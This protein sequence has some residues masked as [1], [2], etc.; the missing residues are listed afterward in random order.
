MS[1]TDPQFT[2]TLSFQE[3]EALIRRVV[4]DAIHEEDESLLETRLT[5]CRQQPTPTG[6]PTQW[7]RSRPRLPDEAPFDFFYSSQAQ[8]DLE[9][10]R[11]TD[12]EVRRRI[13]RFLADIALRPFSGIGKPEPLRH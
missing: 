4:K 2:I 12:K 7:V 6:L 5:C 8:E 1:A 3:M 10:W 13:D 9:Y 11:R